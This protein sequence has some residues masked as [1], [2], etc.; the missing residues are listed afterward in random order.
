MKKTF[1][2][3]CFIGVAFLAKADYYSDTIKIPIITNGY[4]NGKTTYIDTSTVK[5]R[6][7]C[8]GQAGSY[9]SY[10]LGDS[11]R[12]AFSTYTANSI[13]QNQ[14]MYGNASGIPT[15]S[16]DMTWDYTN[17]LLETNGYFRWGNISQNTKTYHFTG[18]FPNSQ[19]STTFV[20]LPIEI[21]ASKIVRIDI[22]GQ[23][24]SNAWMPRNFTIFN[25]YQFDFYTDNG[26]PMNINVVLSNS[27]SSSMVNQIF[28][29]I[30]EY[31]Y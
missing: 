30:V 18:T 29:G 13:G 5:R 19:G 16:A 11:I 8:C 25:G 22:L 24:S 10:Y 14:I 9:T 21:I 20:T 15:S 7:S 23:Y 31:K 3:I 2:L 4:N 1:T 12:N 27:N 26:S 28:V 17:G 6:D